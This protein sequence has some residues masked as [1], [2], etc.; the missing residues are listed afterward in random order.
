[1]SDTYVKLKTIADLQ[2]ESAK[3]Y[4]DAYQRGYRWTENEVRD[5]LD[6]IREFSHAKRQDDRT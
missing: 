3:F 4:I 1:M 5:L 6:D 2:N